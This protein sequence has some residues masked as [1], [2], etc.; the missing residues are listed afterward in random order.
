MI[1]SL[2]SSH[3]LIKQFTQQKYFTRWARGPKS[4][5]T[6]VN[7][8]NC[9]KKK[10]YHRE[11][12]T[13]SARGPKAHW[14][15]GS[16]IPTAATSPKNIAS[17]SPKQNSSKI[18][19][20]QQQNTNFYHVQQISHP[21]S[22]TGNLARGFYSHHV[23]AGSV[24]VHFWFFFLILSFFYPKKIALFGDNVYWNRSSERPIMIVEH[25]FQPT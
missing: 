14:H 6:V 21:N 4:F 16:L 24:E 22:I 13:R 8:C 10:K 12:S 19:P 5:F 17:L 20:K 18:H 11:D 23:D 15:P 2:M 9:F 1:P 25:V 3:N 7:S